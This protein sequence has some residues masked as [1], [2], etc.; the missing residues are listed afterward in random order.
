[1]EEEE[2][3]PCPAAEREAADHEQR[4]AERSAD[5]PETVERRRSRR[6]RGG[7]GGRRNRRGRLPHVASARALV[8]LRGERGGSALLALVGHG[9]G[10]RCQA[11]GSTLRRPGPWRNRP[12]LLSRCRAPSRRRR[13]RRRGS[14]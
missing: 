5:R 1:E 7:S 10:V 12:W 11:H 2:P 14:G 13:A 9:I 8:P 4:E 3:R 6:A